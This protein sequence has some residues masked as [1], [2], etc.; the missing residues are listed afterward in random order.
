VNPFQQLERAAEA[1]EGLALT[2]AA[3]KELAEVWAALVADKNR[4]TAEA[5]ERWRA[6]WAVAWLRAWPGVVIGDRFA[7]SGSWAAYDD[8]QG[9]WGV[10]LPFEGA[11]GGDYHCLCAN[12]DRAEAEAVAALLNAMAAPV[13]GNCF[14]SEGLADG[15]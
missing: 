14:H 3:V 13:T 9:D 7:P 2:P 5:W 1:G 12:M 4:L 15:D 8:G 10:G 11:A 6:G